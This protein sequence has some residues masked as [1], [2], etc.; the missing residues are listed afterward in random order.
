VPTDASKE[1]YWP[2]AVKEVN[3]SLLVIFTGVL[4]YVGYLQWRTLREHGR[5]MKENVK[6]AEKAAD[7]ARKSADAA[8]DSS[9]F[10]RDTIKKSE[11]AEVLLLLVRTVP[12]AG[13][14]YESSL[15]LT[16]KNFGRTRAVNVSGNFSFADDIPMVGA[17]ENI[18]K[19]HTI[20]GAG[21]KHKLIFDKFINI[22]D[23]QT[24]GRVVNNQ[25][26][27][28]FVGRFT[29]EDIFGEV[30]SAQCGGRF[31]PYTKTFIIEENRAG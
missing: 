15:E 11:R 9:E 20:L 18:R 23:G 26:T 10:T 17:K 28:R 19:V 21:Q 2:Q 24:F 7:A 6:I 31:D 1:Y 29:Y 13:S 12:K 8:Y 25:Q 5:W 30:H 27:M 22:F 3:D 4:A 14:F 16:I